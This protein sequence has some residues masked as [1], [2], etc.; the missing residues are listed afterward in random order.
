[1]VLG[2]FVDGRV[3]LREK[4]RVVGEAGGLLKEDFLVKGDGVWL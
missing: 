2:V 4:G 1:V 3:L